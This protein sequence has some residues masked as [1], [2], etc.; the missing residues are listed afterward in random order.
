MSASQKP[1][2]GPRASLDRMRAEIASGDLTY[3]RTHALC[4][5]A[6]ALVQL[7]APEPPPPPVTVPEPA[8]ASV[9]G[10]RLRWAPFCEELCSDCAPG[11]MLHDVP[12]GEQS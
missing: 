4:A 10:C 12:V 3:A 1:A 7:V 2:P 6:E 9:E 11:G 5:I 8:P